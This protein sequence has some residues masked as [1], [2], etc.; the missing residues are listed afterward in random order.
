LRFTVFDIVGYKKEND[1]MTR[2]CL[3]AS[4]ERTQRI[5]RLL[6]GSG[7]WTKAKISR[8]EHSTLD[9]EKYLTIKFVLELQLP[10]RKLCFT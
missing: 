1:A 4:A 3:R 9:S 8:S 10:L 2:S 6:I 7:G 5:Q